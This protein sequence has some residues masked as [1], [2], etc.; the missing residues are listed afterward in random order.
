VSVH[1]GQARDVRHGVTTPGGRAVAAA[2]TKLSLVVASILAAPLAAYAQPTGK[3]YRIGYLYSGSATSSLRAPEALR[4]ELRELGWVEGRNIVIDYRFAEGR[5]DR[6]PDLA[7]DLVRLKVDVIV[8]WPT[9]PAVAAKNATGTIPIVMIGVGY[10]VELGLIASLA[11]PGRNVTGVSFN[12]DMEIGKGLELLTET[13]SKLRRVAIL[14]NPANPSH[15]RAVSIVKAAARSLGVSLQ[16]LE[17]REPNQ[18]EGAFAAMATGRVEALLVVTDSM[19]ILHRARL[20]NLA[21]KNRLPSVFGV[22]E[23]V[24]AGGLMSYGVSV[25]DLMRRGAAVVDKIL[26]GARPG[27]LPVEQPTKF[28]LVLNLKAAKAMGLTMPQSLLQR[29]DQVIE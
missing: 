13:V 29:A 18:F 11:R 14:S 22:R 2:V 10:P 24:D 6:L 28:E 26:K 9:P 19:F 17:A 21:A 16:V 20:V 7:A 27:D 8:A 4:A 1:V 15:A 25:P 5:F 23:F 12:A 3:V